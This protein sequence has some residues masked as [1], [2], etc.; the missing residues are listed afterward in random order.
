MGGMQE[1]R[2]G[3]PGQG[4][5]CRPKEKQC[6][7][8]LGRGD[9]GAK[10]RRRYP[11]MPTTEPGAPATTPDRLICMNRGRRTVTGPMVSCCPRLNWHSRR[12]PIP[13]TYISPKVCRPSSLAAFSSMT[14][15]LAPAPVQRAA[16]E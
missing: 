9:E 14:K 11:S 4:K 12:P 13:A 16:S 8:G 2:G 1:G 7:M 3:E 15:P 5:G 10:E 6:V